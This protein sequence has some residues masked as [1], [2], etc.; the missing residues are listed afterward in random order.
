MRAKNA[1][2]NARHFWR[3]LHERFSTAFQKLLIFNVAFLHLNQSS[4]VKSKKFSIAL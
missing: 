4:Q 2:T 1:S 3:Q